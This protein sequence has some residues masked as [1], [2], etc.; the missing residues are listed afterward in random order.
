MF[1]G[2]CGTQI[3]DE[4]MFC[5]SCGKKNESC[6]Q[7]DQTPLVRQTPVPPV[8]GHATGEV[9]FG[10]AVFHRKDG[11]GRY[12]YYRWFDGDQRHGCVLL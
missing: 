7:Q 4:A 11:F 1:C 9:F 6:S 8:K 10:I 12:V 5:P 3:P 2:H